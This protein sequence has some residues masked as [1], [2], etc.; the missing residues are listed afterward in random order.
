MS[1]D[2]LDLHLGV[3]N[4]ARVFKI[5][6]FTLG[7]L[8]IF[9]ASFQKI[10]AAGGKLDNLESYAHVTQCLVA[11]LSRDHEG[12]DAAAIEGMEITQEQLITAVDQLGDFSGLFKK[13]DAESGEA[14]AMTTGQ[15]S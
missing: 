5:R 12:M 13:K 6:R 11:A 3:G 8:K 10:I 4:D 7:Q 2:I 1:Q 9:S 14:Q 15:S